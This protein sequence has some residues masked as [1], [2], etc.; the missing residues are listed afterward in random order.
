MEWTDIA[1]AARATGVREETILGWA[2]RHMTREEAYQTE[3]RRGSGRA[4]CI[5]MDALQR[6]A[7]SRGRVRWYPELARPAGHE[8]VRLAEVVAAQ[9]EEIARL[10]EQV[11]ALVAAGAAPV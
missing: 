11:R 6:V 9:R 4:W 8:A 7:A 5:R 10:Q 3:E 2:R 1:G